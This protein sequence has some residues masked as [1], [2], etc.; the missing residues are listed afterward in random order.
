ME[1]RH[2]GFVK[3]AVEFIDRGLTVQIQFDDK[4][5]CTV[6]IFILPLQDYCRQRA[7]TKRANTSPAPMAATPGLSEFMLQ[8]VIWCLSQAVFSE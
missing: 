5:S 1:M 3:A 2:T 8:S 7:C 6:K 4:Q